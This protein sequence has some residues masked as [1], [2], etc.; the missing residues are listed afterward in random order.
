MALAML[1]PSPCAE[2]GDLSAPTT[3]V[4]R[5]EGTR[6]IVVLLG[7][8][9]IS[10]RPVVSDAL[11]RMIA[12]GQ[13]DVVIDLSDTD[14]MDTAIGRALAKGSADAGSPRP[15]GHLPVAV[16]AGRECSS[17]RHRGGHRTE[18]TTP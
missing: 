12:T 1:A 15:P 6:T 13:G 14:F 9:D 16:Q 17:T 3:V 18:G 8:A 4:L 2:H 11:S 7:E 5:A 10:S